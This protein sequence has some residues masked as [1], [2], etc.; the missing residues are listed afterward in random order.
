M[1]ITDDRSRKGLTSAE[2]WQQEWDSFC[3]F[4][5]ALAALLGIELAAAERAEGSSM[6][7]FRFLG[8]DK[9]NDT[10]AWA[11]AYQRLFGEMSQCL[12]IGPVDTH[13]HLAEQLAAQHR[14]RIGGS[15]RP[16]F[17]FVLST[18][19]NGY[20][21]VPMRASVNTLRAVVAARRAAVE[22]K[23]A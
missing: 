6:A 16:I 19:G 1:S 15:V 20:T 9:R 22:D 14:L 13:L 23:A 10:A 17:G 3:E 8:A 5:T 11:A 21:V 12:P 18:R 2:L 4:V 7:S